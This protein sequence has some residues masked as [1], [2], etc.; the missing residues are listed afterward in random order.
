VTTSAEQLDQDDAPAATR[1]T[2]RA[3]SARRHLPLVG[4]VLAVFAVGLVLRWWLLRNEFGYLN[5]DEAV[6]GIMSLRILQ[7]HPTWMIAHQDYGGTLEAWLAAPI[8][9]VTGP[10]RLVLKGINLAAWLA[11]VVVCYHLARTALSRTGAA[12]AALVVWVMSFVTLWLSTLA[13]AGYATGLLAAVACMLVAA[14]Q[15]AADRPSWGAAF[16]AGLFAGLAVWLHPMYLALV[17]PAL[18]VTTWRH[19]RQL[20]RWLPATVVGGIVGAAPLLIYNM[21]NGWPSLDP[22]D[23]PGPA[24]GY[25]GM[26]KR[27]VLD[28]WPRTFGFRTVNGEWLSPLHLSLYLVVLAVAVVGLVRL[29]TRSWP[30]RV[31]G[32]TGLAAPFVLALFEHLSFFRDGR[33]GIALVVPIAIGV[34][35]AVE[36]GLEAAPRA[37]KVGLVALPVLWLLV[38]TIP[39]FQLTPPDRNAIQERDIA[40][41]VKRLDELG[42]DK[43]RTDY[44]DAQ[45]L[46]FATDQRILADDLPGVNRFPFIRRELEAADP[47]TVAYVFPVGTEPVF[48]RSPLS[49]ED[50]TPV[51]AGKFVIYVP[52]GG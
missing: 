43:V 15:A 35:A 34:V 22:P 30:G 13:Y 19:R 20:A 40:D 32:V 9:A 4:I 21:A 52:D 14:R 6:T 2:S 47:R 50:Y 31:I 17:V 45:R 23:L 41:L 48:E 44:F 26:W 7:G 38:V 1:P 8:M 3:E 42:I 5:G 29:I 16:L 33:Y 51:E 11:L 39:S 46:V 28:L 49:P 12:A 24:V 37:A 10:S 27:F 36:W 25:P 18:V